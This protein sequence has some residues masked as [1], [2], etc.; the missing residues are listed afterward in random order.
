MAEPATSERMIH[1]LGRVM[2][3]ARWLMAPIYL[4]LLVALLLVLVK[5]AQKLVL[6]FPE[7]LGAST[8]DTILAVLSLVD[9]SLVANLLLIV[10]L[11][12][13]QG[14]VDPTLSARSEDQPTWIALDFSAIKLKLVGSLAAI[15][16]VALLET[17]VH[18]GAMAAA[19]VGWELAIVLGFGVLGVLLA[20]MDRLGKGE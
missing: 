9:L 3:G 7:V 15:A 17:F 1:H 13:W 8:S 5:F 14:F 10:V 19:T 2:L 16:A 4:G 6:F 11:A 20:V 12:G 18:I